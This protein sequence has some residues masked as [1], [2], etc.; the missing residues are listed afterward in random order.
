LFKLAA[1]VSIVTVLLI[2]YNALDDVKALR[3]GH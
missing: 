1:T 2:N 3:F